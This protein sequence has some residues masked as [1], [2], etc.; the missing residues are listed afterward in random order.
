M[1]WGLIDRPDRLLDSAQLAVEPHALSGTW[2]EFGAACQL[3]IYGSGSAP[4]Y[5]SGKL[6]WHFFFSGEIRVDAVGLFPAGF[7]VL[8]CCLLFHI[9]KLLVCSY[10]WLG[11]ADN[12]RLHFIW[13][14]GNNGNYFW[15]FYRGQ[16]EPEDIQHVVKG[17]QT[18]GKW[19]KVMPESGVWGSVEVSPNRARNSGYASHEMWGKGGVIPGPEVIRTSGLRGYNYN[20]VMLSDKCACYLIHEC[21][22]KQMW[23]F[24]PL[25]CLPLSCQWEEEI[26][27]SL[28]AAEELRWLQN[29]E[30]QL[31]LVL[32]CVCVLGGP[33]HWS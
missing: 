28:H 14:T 5:I 4:V 27:S 23:R 12:H 30:N 26:I 19:A 21:V 31:W 2:E 8:C 17:P 24:R 9:Q 18:S 1:S 32:T 29:S 3:S 20:S 10:H 25:Q 11:P 7:V 33:V 13:A 6:K 22:F 15:C 16:R